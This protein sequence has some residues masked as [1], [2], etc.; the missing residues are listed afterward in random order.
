MEQNY[1]VRLLIYFEECWLRGLNKSIF[2]LAN[3]IVKQFKLFGLVVLV[4]RNLQFETGLCLRQNLLLDLIED[5]LRQFHDQ[6]LN[7]IK[8]LLSQVP[9]NQVFDNMQVFRGELEVCCRLCP[10]WLHMV[11][12]CLDSLDNDLFKYLLPPHQINMRPFFF[13]WQFFLQMPDFHFKRLV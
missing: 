3:L 8:V 13:H 6:V 11:L 10:F 5:V 4:L 9:N 2:E 12:N 7:F 1:W